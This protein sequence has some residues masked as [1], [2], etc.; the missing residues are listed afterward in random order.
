MIH[1]FHYTPYR[2]GAVF[3]AQVMDHEVFGFGATEAEAL[4]NL[5]KAVELYLEDLPG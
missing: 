2:E 3:V 1:G 5:R 4:V